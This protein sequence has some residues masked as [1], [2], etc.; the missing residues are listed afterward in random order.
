MCQRQRRVLAPRNA[1][2]QLMFTFRQSSKGTQS[3]IC[4]QALYKRWRTE[5][6]QYQSPRR[7]LDGCAL[8]DGAV[9]TKN[10]SLLSSQLS[11]LDHII[12]LSFDCMVNRAK[13]W[14]CGSLTGIQE[15][16]RSALCTKKFT[17]PF[18]SKVSSYVCHRVKKTER[19]ETRVT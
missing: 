5:I 1:H 4:P 11:F 19:S 12:C 10:S 8:R 13:K 17:F 9:L 16:E 15:T 3:T 7:C 6:T 14:V 18:D 2:K